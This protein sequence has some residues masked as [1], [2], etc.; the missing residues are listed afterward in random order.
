MPFESHQEMSETLTRLSSQLRGFRSLIAEQRATIATELDRVRADRL[1]SDVRSDRLPTNEAADSN[2]SP[3]CG[4]REA[5]LPKEYRKMI[6]DRAAMHVEHRLWESEDSL[7]REELGL[8]SEDVEGAMAELKGLEGTLKRHRDALQEE[9]RTLEADQALVQDHEH[10]MA[11]FERGFDDGAAL[12]ELAKRHEQNSRHRR[13]RFAAFEALKKR[14]HQVMAYW[15]LLH[16]ALSMPVE[17][18]A[19]ISR[20]SL[21]AAEAR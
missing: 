20:R 13:D 7:R 18:Q 5:P 8:W 14:H 19:P 11:D 17:P 15:H 3:S 12:I 6:E 2:E 16:Q 1:E 4:A 21:D 10:L 9:L